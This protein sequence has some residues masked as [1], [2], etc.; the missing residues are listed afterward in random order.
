MRYRSIALTILCMLAGTSPARAL[1]L[2]DFQGICFFPEQPS[3]RS[4]AETPSQDWLVDPLTLKEAIS[5]LKQYPDLRV[6]LVGNADRNECSGVECQALSKRRADTVA[7]W[8]LTGGV[9]ALRIEHIS[10]VGTSDPKDFEKTETQ[11]SHNRC[12]YVMPNY[13]D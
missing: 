5:V 10:G 3:H 11:R 4:D 7:T 1:E 2:V 8:L 13:G 12:V 9:A 6:S